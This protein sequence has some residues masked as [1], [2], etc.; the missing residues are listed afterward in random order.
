MPPRFSLC[1]P[2][3]HTTPLAP[4]QVV[5]NLQTPPTLGK[6]ELRLGVHVGPVFA[7][8][9]GVKFPRYSFFGTTMRL[10]KALTATALPMT[11]H[12]SDMVYN[13]VKVR[14]WQGGVAA[15]G[16]VQVANRMRGHG[17]AEVKQGDEVETRRCLFSIHMRAFPDPCTMFF[18]PCFAYTRE[19]LATASWPSPRAP[20]RAWAWCAPTCCSP[21]TW[22]WRRCRQRTS[23]STSALLHR[24]QEGCR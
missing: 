17:L 21:A 14:G 22:T 23:G 11:V 15:A 18:F 24:P 20:S 13:R 16:G 19:P 6:L 10:A 5:R 12:I 3:P 9:V 2:C 4:L 8:V 1:V 7:G